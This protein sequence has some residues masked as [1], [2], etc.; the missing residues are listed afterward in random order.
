MSK[1]IE[2]ELEKQ[3]KTKKLELN[4]EKTMIISDYK[5]IGIL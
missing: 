1:K 5:D 4:R 2:N 3:L